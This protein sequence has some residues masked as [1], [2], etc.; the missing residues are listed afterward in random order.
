MKRTLTPPMSDNI[1][2]DC[3]TH[4]ETKREKEIRIKK[5]TYTRKIKSMNLKRNYTLSEQITL[6]H[7]H[8]NYR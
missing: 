6:V 1:A 3:Y 8:A 4:S 2:G 5:R 7:I